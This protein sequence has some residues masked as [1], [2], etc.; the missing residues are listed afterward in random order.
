M[1]ERHEPA[2]VSQIV[3]RLHAEQSRLWTDGQPRR[4]ADYL[5]EHPWLREHPQRVVD[6]IYWEFRLREAQ[7][8]SPQPREYCDLF[9]ELA[10]LLVR[11]FEVHE[12]LLGSATDVS[13]EQ[14][15]ALAEQHHEKIR[16]RS[17][18][19]RQYGR[20]LVRR[21]LGRGGFGR[22][23]AAWDPELEREVAIK[24]LSETSGA[25]ADGWDL[26]QEARKVASVS[27]PAIVPV[28]DFGEQ[29][30]EFYIVSRLIAGQSLAQRLT[31]DRCSH[32]TAIRLAARIAD[33]LQHAHEAGLIHRDVKP[34]NI[35]LDEQGRAYLT[36]FGLSLRTTERAAR[37]GE[38]AGTLP[39]M[40]PEMLTGQ[41]DRV[42]PASDLFSLGVVLYELLTG[43]LPFPERTC[44]ERS[45]ASR[46][47]LPPAPRSLDDTIPEPLEQLCLW[48]LAH[49]PEA[50]PPTAR[51]FAA[52]LRALQRRRVGVATDTPSLPSS[53]PRPPALLTSTIGRDRELDELRR[54]VAYG[55]SRLVTILGPGGVGKSRLCSAVGHELLEE[56]PDG[57]A[58]IG[59][60]AV[61]DEALVIPQINEAL[62]YESRPGESSDATLIRHLG[63]RPA[64]LLL[65]NLEQ[66]V[67]AGPRL[68]AVLE[69]CPRLQLVVTSRVALEVR[70][71]TIFPLAPLPLVDTDSATSGSATSPAVRLFADRAAAI[72]PDFTLREDNVTAVADICRRLD[73]LPLAIELAAARLSTYSPVELLERLRQGLRVLRSGARDLPPRQRTLWDTIAWSYDLLAPATRSILHRLSL[74]AG[75]VPLPAAEDFLQRLGADREETREQCEQLAR[76]SLLRIDRSTTPYRM[77]L[78]ETIRDFAREQLVAAGEEDSVL[79]TWGH[80]CLDLVEQARQHRTGPAQAEWTTR[81]DQLS[82]CLRGVLQEAADGQLA[83]ELGLRLSA[84]LWWYWELRGRYEEGLH[85]LTEFLQAAPAA[86]PRLRAD[87]LNAAGNLTRDL[88]RFTEAER[89]Y[90]AALELR[91]TSGDVVGLGIVLQNL[92]NVALERGDLDEAEQLYRQSL[93]IRRSV[94]DD[95]GTAMTLSNLAVVQI[96]RGQFATTRSLLDE[97]ESR[98]AALGDQL[99]VA[100]VRD[101]RGEA[102][103]GWGDFSQAEQEHRAALHV[104][105]QRGNR[106]GMALS[107]ENLAA[108]LLAQQ[109]LA[110]AARCFAEALA[111]YQE[112]RQVRELA[113]L[114]R[115]A[116]QLAYCLSDSDTAA[117]LLDC[118]LTVLQEAGFDH[119]PL[120][121]ATFRASGPFAAEV[122]AQLAQR[123]TVA[124]HRPVTPAGWPHSLATAATLLDQ[125][126]SRGAPR[127]PSR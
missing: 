110:E 83:A 55:S 97:A 81:L 93:E 85:W 111:I 77:S 21:E 5:A 53:W 59:L 17:D 27:H 126:S 102:A 4:V 20:Y 67:A 74:L 46:D 50:R 84:A 56:F 73:G 123:Q 113:R 14:S 96:H 44:A 106:L 116:A 95:W 122:R 7:G 23:Y 82:D 34:A 127:P 54:L 125:L 29:Q 118:S 48:A 72:V 26:R 36:D 119:D 25:D 13:V 33:G 101:I 35:L 47:P 65:D 115:S 31:A 70:G 42:G 10:S 88:A 8:E 1:T 112:L 63:A 124:Q 61:T 16:E 80:W 18:T 12:Q 11:Q 86:D 9:P 107:L 90:H 60:S 121:R 94:G 69:R 100:R 89:H 117:Q 22:V 43:R 41:L 58:F 109:Q 66:V 32:A 76:G 49:E 2:F 103:Q 51:L 99:N 37:A 62:G 78:L 114:L 64:I 57:V 71:E 39:Y 108:A 24:L 3:D 45:T 19:A 98:F 87:A 68:V 6:L 92:G 38:I 52:R 15:P 104:R 79:T 40:A 120:G 28:Y 30:G 75:Q 91:R 105:R